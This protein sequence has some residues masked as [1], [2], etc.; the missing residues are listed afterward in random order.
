VSTWNVL[1]KFV[2]LVNIWDFQQVL[3][4]A[5]DFAF[6]HKPS[7]S[8]LGVFFDKCGKDLRIYLTHIVT[9]CRTVIF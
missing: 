8:V 3:L 5:L 9:N 6:I 4:A 7:G 1:L 2:F